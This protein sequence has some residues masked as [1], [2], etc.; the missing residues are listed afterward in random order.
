LQY[1]GRQIGSRGRPGQQQEDF[2]SLGG[3]GYRPAP[4]VFVP[5]P[6]VRHTISSRRQAGGSDAACDGEGEVE[7]EQQPLSGDCERDAAIAAA[8]GVGRAGEVAGF[9]GEEPIYTTQAIKFA[10]KNPEWT[11]A[12]ERAMKGHVT[13]TAK[14]C[15]LQPM[16]RQKRK[17]VHEM[18]GHF[19]FETQS[20][21]RDPNRCARC[22]HASDLC[23]H[24]LFN[25]DPT[26]HTSYPK[27]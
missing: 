13:S 22:G 9:K 26:P 3:T 17:V 2:P 4:P 27:T 16:S 7:Q 5:T 1:A 8:F 23:F 20:F 25:V 14:K 21:D 15:S 18:A 24:A 19:G 10:R 11:A 6:I 12:V